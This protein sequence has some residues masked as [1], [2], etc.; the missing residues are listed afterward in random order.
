MTGPIRAATIV[1]QGISPAVKS[2]RIEK[3]ATGFNFSVGPYIYGDEKYNVR[4]YP[5]RHPYAKYN[6]SNYLELDFRSPPKGSIRF[7]AFFHRG[8]DENPS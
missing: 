2:F 1:F 6:S 3:I 7:V 4:V 5:M 8:D